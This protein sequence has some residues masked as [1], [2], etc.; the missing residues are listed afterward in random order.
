MCSA[1][2]RRLVSHLVNRVHLSSTSIMD[3]SFEKEINGLACSHHRGHL[4]M[5]HLVDKNNNCIR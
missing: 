2:L 1:S 4:L 3:A 5:R